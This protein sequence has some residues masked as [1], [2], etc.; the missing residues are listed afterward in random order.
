M[1]LQP[2]TRVEIVLTE[3]GHNAEVLILLSGARDIA[4][5]S[6][7]MISFWLL[8]SVNQINSR[9]AGQNMEN[10]PKKKFKFTKKHFIISIVFV[11]LVAIIVFLVIKLMDN[12][13]PRDERPTVV[14]QENAAA[15]R[16][17]MDQPVEDGS[18]EVNMNTEWTFEKKKSDAFV[19][20]SENNTRTVYFDVFI[21]DTKELIYSSPY[22]PTGEKVQGF[23][24]DKELEPGD[25]KGLVTYHLV[26]DNHEE[27]SNLS[28]TVKIK[29]K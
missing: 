14:T 6:D 11:I 16:A 24:L 23:Q 9:K 4:D 27:V 10:S 13:R 28:V 12:G 18:Y 22:I 15:V 17:S 26:D 21:E 5:N 2:D 3:A 29:V 8:G 1:V 25:Y 20:N 19:T 7:S